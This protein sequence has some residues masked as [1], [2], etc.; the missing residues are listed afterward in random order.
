MSIGVKSSNETIFEGLKS[1][2][3]NNLT[4]E[5]ANTIAH[6]NCQLTKQMLAEWEHRNE[7]AKKKA[8][9]RKIEEGAEAA[10][11][12]KGRRRPPGRFAKRQTNKLSL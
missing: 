7:K 2:A 9:K 11:A 8:A 10:A 6:Y 5:E 3:Q 4:A 12:D 1:A